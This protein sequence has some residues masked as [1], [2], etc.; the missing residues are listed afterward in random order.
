MGKQE[1]QVVK[2]IL[3]YSD[4]PMIKHLIS[5]IESI[6]LYKMRNIRKID[7]EPSEWDQEPIERIRE[8]IATYESIGGPM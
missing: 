8:A 6:K 2:D 3:K 5:S 1:N 7:T 4:E